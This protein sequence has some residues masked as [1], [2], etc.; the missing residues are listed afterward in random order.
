[1]II[2]RQ[3][4]HVA[5]SD[6]QG[7]CVDTHVHRICNRLGWVSKP[8]TKQVLLKDDAYISLSMRLV[9]KYLL[10]FC[11][12]LSGLCHPFLFCS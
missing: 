9:L 11:I 4:L 3:V 1:M 12:V 10:K 7:I 2:L 5:W 8:G 6:V